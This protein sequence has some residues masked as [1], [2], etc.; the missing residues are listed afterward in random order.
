M[1]ISANEFSL[2]IDEELVNSTY[3]KLKKDL[4]GRN[5]SFDKQNEDRLKSLKE[6]IFFL[7]DANKLLGHQIETQIQRAEELLKNSKGEAEDSTL[8]FTSKV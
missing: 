6:D 5:K 1:K 8:T 2:N 4:E 3:L 7:K